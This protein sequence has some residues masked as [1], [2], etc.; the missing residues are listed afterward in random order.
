[1]QFSQQQIDDFNVALNEAQLVGIEVD[2]LGPRAAIT[3]AVLSLPADGG[4]E[5]EDPRVQFVLEPLGRVAASL[6][7]GRWDDESARIE[8]FKLE[9]LADVVSA[10]GQLPIYGWEFLDVP[11]EKDFDG[12]RDRLSLDW[13]TNDDVGQTH[14]LDLF[15]E[16]Q[17]HLDLRLWFDE[18]QIFDPARQL[19]AFD[20]FTA[21]G[22]RWWD[23]LYAGDPRTQAHGIV[24]LR[25]DPP[26]GG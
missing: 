26:T 14:T 6:R 2:P 20:D 11:A 7:H 8:H 4:P 12:W 25:T 3:L 1:M 19:I 24:P 5:P 13:T 10:R 21:A 18:I 23:A 17:P 16:D 15:Q 22:V 9:Q